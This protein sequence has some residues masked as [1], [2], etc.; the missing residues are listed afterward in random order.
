M[1]AP[2]RKDFRVRVGDAV[3]ISAKSSRGSLAAGA[4]PIERACLLRNDDHPDRRQHAVN[5]R[6]GHRHADQCTR[7]RASMI[8]TQAAKT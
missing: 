7:S 3:G 4:T 8:C 5:D 1:K 6:R 2:E